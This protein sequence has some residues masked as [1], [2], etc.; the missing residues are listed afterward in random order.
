VNDENAEIAAKASKGL[1][2]KAEF[3]ILTHEQQTEYNNRSSKWEAERQSDKRK[4]ADLEDVQESFKLL[5]EAIDNV[6]VDKLAIFTKHLAMAR[7]TKWQLRVAT[8]E[9]IRTRTKFTAVCEYFLAIDRLKSRLR[10]SAL[11]IYS[12]NALDF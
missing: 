6:P 7:I 3:D 1:I 8:V 5:T 4:P 11:D 2:S 9:I 12:D 10:A